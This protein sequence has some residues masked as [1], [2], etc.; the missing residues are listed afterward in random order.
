MTFE[1]ASQFSD[2]VKAVI[3][4]PKIIN[5]IITQEIRT[6]HCK[7][8]KDKLDNGGKP[9]TQHQ[10]DQCIA[11]ATGDMEELQRLSDL[12]TSKER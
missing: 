12:S 9:I 4:D 10:I 1:K 2:Q 6:Q 5:D 8:L 11:F 7:D 3:S